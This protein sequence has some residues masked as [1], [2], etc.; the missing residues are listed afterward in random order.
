M[1]DRLIV[2]RGYQ[3]LRFRLNFYF[4]LIV[5]YFQYQRTRQKTIASAVNVSIYI[6][7]GI[8]TRSIGLAVILTIISVS[9]FKTDVTIYTYERGIYAKNILIFPHH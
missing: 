7:T 6:I 1:T 4:D 3:L 5:R 9:T 8:T 2:T